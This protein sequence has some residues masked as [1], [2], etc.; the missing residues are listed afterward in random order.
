MPQ[1]VAL[2]VL[3]AE[4]YG[5]ISGP[6]GTPRDWDRFLGLFHP[7]QGRLAAVMHPAEGPPKVFAMTPEKYRQNAEALF[8]KQGFYEQEI[9][10]RVERFG[11][12]A[13]VFSTYE[14]RHE[15]EAEPFARGINSLQLVWDGDRWL[16][17]AILWDQEIPE[18]PI[19]D[20]Y[21]P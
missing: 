17:M 21:L 2:D 15:P 6:A 20:R 9:A 12:I 19:P 7:E 18:S 4:L 3:M 5:V 13:H 8:A 10:R 14:S 11:A 16:I 1:D